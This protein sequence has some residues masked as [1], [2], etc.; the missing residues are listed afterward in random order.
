[1][2]I[3]TRLFGRRS[4][5]TSRLEI[6][7][8]SP[9]FTSFAGSDPWAN[10]VYRSGV[11]AIAR[12][13]AKFVLQPRVS[14]T[15]GTTADADERLARVLQVEPNPYMSAYDML[16]QLVASLYVDGNSYAYVHREGGQV[17]GLYPLHVTSC[18][19]VQGKDGALCAFTFANGKSTILPY[20][21]IVHLRR[22]FKSGDV[23]GDRPA[24]DA[25]VALADAQNDGIRRSI[26]QGGR[27]RGIVRYASALG[28]SKLEAYKR[29]FEESNLKANASGVIIT[30][31]ALDYTPIADTT[32]TIDAAD[33]AETRRKIFDSLGIS[34]AIVSGS[35]DDDEFA[36]FDESTVE[37]LALQL[38][39]ELTRKVYT[40]LQVARGRRIECSTARIRFIGMRNRVEL[41]RNVVP[42][43]ILS[44]NEARDL[45]GL[46]PLD[47]DRTLQS[48]NYIDVDDAG[49]YQRIRALLNARKDGYGTRVAQGGDHADDQG[50]EHE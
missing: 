35:F 5:A 43:G 25:A 8:A 1:M 12:I 2:S 34:E 10:D 45:M 48:L 3:F 17:V 33:V 22:H 28:P 24:I 49:D 9:T 42:M 39:L 4:A 32:P 36:A 18:E 47:E 27:L 20:A 44:V 21:D 40:P 6:T 41:L 26:E 31:T 23:L 37:A 38:S 7:G 14:F 15:D 30:D 46:A 19:V 11:D 16:Y 13:C 29:Q 50:G